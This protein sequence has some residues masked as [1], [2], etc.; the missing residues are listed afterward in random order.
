MHTLVSAYIGFTMYSVSISIINKGIGEGLIDDTGLTAFS[1]S[2]TEITS[3][4]TK[5]F[6]NDEDVLFAI[7]KKMIQFFLELLQVAGTDLNISKCA[8]FTAFRRWKGGRATLLRTHDSHP[9]MIRRTRANRSQ[10]PQ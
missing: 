10:E 5:R 6:T 8:C 2:S 3:T 4:R 1:Q 7:M 9:V